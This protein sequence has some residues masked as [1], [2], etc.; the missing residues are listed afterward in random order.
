MEARLLGGSGA[1][2]LLVELLLRGGGVGRGG[3]VGGVS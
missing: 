2:M 3:V 1:G